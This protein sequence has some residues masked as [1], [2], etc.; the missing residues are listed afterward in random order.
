MVHVEPGWDG[1]LKEHD[2]HYVLVPS[3]SAL[4]NMLAETTQWKTREADRATVLF[5]RTE[6]W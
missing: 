5:E 1:F 4:A 3:G 6:K 2:V